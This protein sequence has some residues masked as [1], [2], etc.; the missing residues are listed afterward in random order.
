LKSIE[1]LRSEQQQWRD[2]AQ[3]IVLRAGEEDRGLDPGE[4]RFYEKFTAR[5]DRAD[6]ELRARCDPNLK[7][8]ELQ[9]RR[10][11][12]ETRTPQ[13]D[14]V[15]AL[16]LR[17]QNLER[18]LKEHTSRFGNDADD[19]DRYAQRR[20][21]HGPFA[22]LAERSGHSIEYIHQ[23]AAENRLNE[24]ISAT[25]NR[26]SPALALANLW[27]MKLSWEADG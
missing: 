10:W 23:M 18:Q 11:P 19:F 22:G 12:R 5:A 9:G 20:A 25:D 4:R 16:R 3:E 27:A 7:L 24:V 2:K 1:E 21:A 15:E 8:A 14:K 17:G 13:E 6:A 26:R